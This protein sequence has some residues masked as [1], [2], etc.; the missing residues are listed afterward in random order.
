MLTNRRLLTHNQ[1]LSAYFLLA[2]ALSWSI[3]LPL[4][5][6]YLGIV[7][8]RLPL[9]SHYLVAYGPFFAALIV[10]WYTQ[11]LAGLHDLGQHLV[12]WRLRPFWWIVAFAPLIVG[13]IAIV[14]L[15]LFTESTITVAS[16]GAISFHPPLGA[17]A[18]L[19]WILTFG[20]G[21]EV[22]WRGFALPR[23]GKGRHPLAATLLLAMFWALWH[24]PQLFYYLFEPL[25][26]VG[27]LITLVAGAIV[28]T[29]LFTK[30][31]E[32]ILIVAVW[33]GCFDFMTGTTAGHGMLTTIMSSVVIVW[34]IVLVLIMRHQGEPNGRATN[35]RK[36]MA[37]N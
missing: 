23:L 34:A 33:H 24:L 11:G 5:F 15:N 19:L 30:A 17:G 20:I 9:W 13:Y 3:G 16:L 28:F 37:G 29:W 12:P 2:Y 21:E 27:W 22:G 8:C 7:P 25:K 14:L 35:Y 31:G 26:I 36:G 6:G 10:T 1:S 18:L 4:A 32:N